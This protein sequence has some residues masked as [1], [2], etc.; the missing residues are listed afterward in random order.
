[1]AEGMVTTIE[2]GI[3][4]IEKLLRKSKDTEAA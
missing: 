4:F 3:Y 2:P 1:L